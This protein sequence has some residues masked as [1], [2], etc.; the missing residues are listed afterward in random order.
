MERRTISIAFV[1]NMI[2]GCGLPKRYG[3]DLLERAG[4]DPKSINST[5]ARVSPTQFS[6]LNRWIT[7]ATGDEGMGHFRQPQ[8]RGTFHALAHYQQS[9][10]DLQQAIKR[11]I[12][13]YNLFDFGFSLALIRSGD[14]VQYRLQPDL[15]VTL[16]DF[17][18]E[19]HLMISHHF[20]CWLTGR[21]IPIYRVNFN[22]PAPT[23]SAEY[24]YLFYSDTRFGQDHS[25][26]VL[27]RQYLSLPIIRSTEELA[28]YLSHAPH[29]FLMN[30][31]Q[32]SS[33]TEKIR[34]IIKKSL[35][36]LPSYESIA[37]SLG[38][39]PQT[40][41]RRLRQEGCDYRLLKNEL[42]RDTAIDFLLQDNREIK[43]ISYQLGFSEPSAFIRSF[44][45]W[46]GLTPHQ[47]RDNH[48]LRSKPTSL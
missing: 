19:Q 9:A 25:E 34:Q 44:K 17:V 15:G 16:S 10:S 21:S 36:L 8:K 30:A 18:Y 3:H 11:N 26:I 13:F 43:T 37:N 5:R 45:K 48:A 7:E 4:I 28:E 1:R 47:Y 24:H 2:S 32:G 31:N 42:I 46:T 12:R 38:L 35:P 29:D 41:R 27:H 23:H 14:Y 39:T 22:Y 6:Q 20:L 33:Y 40:L